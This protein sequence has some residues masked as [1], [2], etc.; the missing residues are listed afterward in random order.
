MA[1]CLIG[2]PK[3]K[4][5][6]RTWVEKEEQI[7]YERRMKQMYVVDDLKDMVSALHE[8]EHIAEPYLIEVLWLIVVMKHQYGADQNGGKVEDH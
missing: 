6:I 8:T 5:A 2:D 3:M 4:Q 7:N 1:F